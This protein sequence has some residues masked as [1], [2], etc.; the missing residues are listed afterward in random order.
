MILITKHSKAQYKHP[1]QSVNIRAY[2]FRIWLL[3]IIDSIHHEKL[4]Y[5]KQLIALRISKRSRNLYITK[6][7]QQLFEPIL[8]FQSSPIR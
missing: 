2:L 5:F 1:I 3:N 8:T 7:R 4:Y 6:I